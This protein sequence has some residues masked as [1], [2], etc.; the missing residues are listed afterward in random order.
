MISKLGKKNQNILKHSVKLG[1][2][3]APKQKELVVS[4]GWCSGKGDIFKYLMENSNHQP[5]D[6]ASLLKGRDRK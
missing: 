1:G 3:N 6:L 2:K 5:V 4:S